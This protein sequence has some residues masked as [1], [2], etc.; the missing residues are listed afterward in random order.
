MDR[1]HREVNSTRRYDSTRRRRQARETRRAVLRAAEQQFRTDG[2]AATTIAGV[3]E[4]AG[5]S[6]A[7]IYKSF[8]GKPGL[9]GA[10]RDVALEGDGP[11]PAERRSDDLQ[12]S[13][14]D[15]RALIRGWGTLAGEVAPRVAPILLLVRAAAAVDP[16]LSQLRREMDADR[17]ARM[18][19][20]ARTLADGG[21]LR[22][23]VTVDVAADVLW[24]YSSPELYELLVLE[25]GW[26]PDRY[27]RFIAEAMIAGLL[28]DRE[29]G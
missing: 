26:S 23:G 1:S 7:T 27:S 13:E 15:P 5:V 21:H 2:Y 11:V 25:R 12:A 29:G 20:N 18:T 9:V 24:T 28:P 3:A 8:G 4:A 10:L 19:H 6:V 14:S 16:E 22:V 17:L